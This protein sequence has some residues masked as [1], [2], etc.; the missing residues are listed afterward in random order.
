MFQSIGFTGQYQVHHSHGDGRWEPMEEVS[1]SPDAAQDDPER[2]WHKGR[3][4]RC[5]AC[6]EEFRIADPNEGAFVGPDDF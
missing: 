5:S 6:N 1:V 3:I 4:F 2:S